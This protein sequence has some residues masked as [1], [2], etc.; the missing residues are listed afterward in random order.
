MHRM[1]LPYEVLMDRILSQTFVYTTQKIQ[2]TTKLHQKRLT[3]VWCWY[4]S[5]MDLCLLTCVG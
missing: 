2:T 4:Y 3:Y 5:Y 1:L